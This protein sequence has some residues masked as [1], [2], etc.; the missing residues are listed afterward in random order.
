MYW[1]PSGSVTS[2]G[3]QNGGANAEK[4]IIFAHISLGLTLSGAN[5]D[6]STLVR[7]SGIEKGLQVKLHPL[8][9]TPEPQNK[10]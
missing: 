1:V 8:C 3:E 5:M 6:C 4:S 7:I 2:I 9:Q 10:Q